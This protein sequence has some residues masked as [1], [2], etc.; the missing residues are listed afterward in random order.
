LGALGSLG[1]QPPTGAIGAAL[2]A[3]LLDAGVVAA[4]GVPDSGLKEPLD[5]LEASRI[6]VEYVLREDVAVGMAI[7][8]ELAGQCWA[9]FLKNA[10]LGNCLDGALSVADAMRL[11]LLLLIG[12]AGTGDDDVAHH[13][14]WGRSTTGLIDEI[15]GLP[16][17]VSADTA[18]GEVSEHCRLVRANRRVGALLGSP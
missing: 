15:G 5:A 9:V 3:G 2:V 14:P 1:G 6:G 10:G 16:L 7:G 11:P 18:P 17:A 13:L 12:N 8:A 4:V